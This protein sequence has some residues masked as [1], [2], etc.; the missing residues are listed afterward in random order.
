MNQSKFDLVRKKLL[1]MLDELSLYLLD[2]QFKVRIQAA[3]NRLGHE[4]MNVLIIGE[5]SRGKS[6]FINAI[7]GTPILPSK[8][9]PTTATINLI[10]FDSAKKIEIY[11]RNGKQEEIDLPD[12]KINKFLDNYVTTINQEANQ[13][14][15]IKIKYPG[16]PRLSDCLIVDTPGVNDLDDAREDITY[17]YLSQ[18]DACIFILD[19]QQPLSESER[20][21]LKD[22]VLANDIQRLLF[23]INRIDEIPKSNG[24]TD[25]NT[26]ERLIN[27]VKK[28]IVENTNLSEAPEVYAVSSKQAL[29]G[30]FKE[31]ERNEWNDV[32][33]DFENKLVEF[34][35]LNATKRRFPDHI[36]SV[37]LI[38]NDG[39]NNIEERL[40][41]I[42]LSGSELEIE[43]KKLHDKQHWLNT[44]L[45][46]L[47][48]IIEREKSVLSRNL[49]QS[50]SD[51]LSLLKEKTLSSTKLCSN[52]GDLINLKSSISQGIRDIVENISEIVLEF[53]ENVS[54]RLAGHFS[55]PLSNN[56][57]NTSLTNMVNKIKIGTNI[58]GF[59]FNTFSGK[60]IKINNIQTIGTALVLGG[61]LGHVGAILLGPVGI[62]AAI[63]SSG[64][65]ANK[66]EERQKAAAWEQV[67]LQTIAN[68]SNQINQ[69][70]DNVERTSKEITEKEGINIERIFRD[71]AMAQINSIDIVID[72]QKKLLSDKSI[73]INEQKLILMKNKDLLLKISNDLQSLG[74]NLHL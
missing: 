53:N 61:A 14:S 4:K 66:F 47:S 34:V 64:L 51:K 39:I 24:L 36:N 12:E 29:K 32:F 43:I 44:K 23:V 5:F 59:N 35:S 48:S 6:T 60:E 40:Q 20:R 74:E 9:N 27:Y 38:A 69:I 65:I 55:E 58:S 42:K 72:E 68:V 49:N 62:A 1:N 30:R 28:L 11:Y 31:N 71:Q 41:L 57:V 52:D 13:I 18:A 26:I 25:K 56:H 73:D 17:K 7:L 8:V 54:I 16:N 50:I 19:S 21:F 63:I 22:K 67:R 45:Q 2:E 46:T 70:I 10:E 37:T 33:D 15:Q 3:R